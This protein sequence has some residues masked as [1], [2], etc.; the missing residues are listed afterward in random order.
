MTGRRPLDKATIAERRQ[1]AGRTGFILGVVAALIGGS[2]NL[3][4]AW[5]R[6]TLGASLILTLV[7]LLNVPLFIGL[8]LLAER[9]SRDTS[10]AGDR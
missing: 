7:A 1:R 5:G 8:A 3:W 6:L 4:R 10:G 9:M 2:F